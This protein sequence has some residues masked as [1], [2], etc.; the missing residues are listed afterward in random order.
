MG[1]ISVL[2]DCWLPGIMLRCL[3]FCLGKIHSDD[4]IVTDKCLPFFFNW[5]DANT[6]RSPVKVLKKDWD[7]KNRMGPHPKSRSAGRQAPYL[8]VMKL[9]EQGSLTQ[10]GFK[11]IFG[12]VHLFIASNIDTSQKRLSNCLLGFAF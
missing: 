11:H 6:N 8:A 7:C 10:T 12:F 1:Q 9:M 3:D 4:F 5:E 2:Q